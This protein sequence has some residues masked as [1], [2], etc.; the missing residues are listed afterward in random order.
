MIVDASWIPCLR[1]TRCGLAPESQ[2]RS[3]SAFAY[4]RVYLRALYQREAAIVGTSTI[5]TYF[6]IHSTQILYIFI[7]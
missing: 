3:S 5:I 4:K 1:E 2:L 7:P 6:D